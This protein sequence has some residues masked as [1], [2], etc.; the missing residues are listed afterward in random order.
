[1]KPYQ[2]RGTDGKNWRVVAVSVVDSNQQRAVVVI[3]LPLSPVDEVL[4]HATLVV[5]GVG[6]LALILAFFIA[7]WTVTTVLPAAGP[8][9]KNRCS[10][11]SR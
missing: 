8:G 4:R 3:G 5:V 9:G 2:V 7:S 6:L 11:C 1:M 10:H